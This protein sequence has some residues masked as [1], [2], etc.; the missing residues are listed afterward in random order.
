[1]RRKKYE[2]LTDLKIERIKKI[3]KD[4]PLI[5]S[6]VLADRFGVSKAAINNFFQKVENRSFQVTLHY[7]NIDYVFTRVCSSSRKA[8]IEARERL[9]LLLNLEVGSTIK[10]FT[11]NKDYR[12]FEILKDELKEVI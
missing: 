10:Y 9:E 3:I 1:L 6:S 12:R 7:I 8:L 2:F 4:D 11:A 5:E